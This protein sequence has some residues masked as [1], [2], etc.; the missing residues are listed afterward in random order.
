[1]GHTTS[2]HEERWPTFDPS[3]AAREQ[4]T[5]VVQ[6]N[7]KVRDTIEVNVDITEDEMKD[8]AL[9]SE[10]VRA[11]LGGRAPAKIITKPPKLISLVVTDR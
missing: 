6:V 9:G 11:H 7:G 1:L 2:I 8:L 10:K 3:L 5:M 4:A